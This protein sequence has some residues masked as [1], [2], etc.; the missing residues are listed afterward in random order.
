[1]DM[2]LALHWNMGV[3][4]SPARK[5]EP[6]VWVEVLSDLAN[7]GWLSRQNVIKIQHMP[8]TLLSEPGTKPVSVY[9]LSQSPV[10]PQ[11]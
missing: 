11:S 1:M 2:P 6:T 8:R 7:P 9:L 5:Q 3:H 10:Q 4:S